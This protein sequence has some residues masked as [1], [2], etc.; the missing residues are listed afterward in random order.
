MK[1]TDFVA[2]VAQRTGVT[3]KQA[4]RVI[5]VTF[6]CLGDV[7]KQGDKL[8]WSGFGAFETRERAE[9]EGRIPSTGQKI[10]IPATTIPVF[11]PSKQLKEKINKV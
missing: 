5:D 4:E 8:T 9:R 11:K 7:L 2:L 6:S 1:R 10:I 3:K